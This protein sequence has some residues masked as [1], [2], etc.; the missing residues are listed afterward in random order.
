MT[1]NSALVFIL[2]VAIAQIPFLCDLGN[3]RL[4]GWHTGTWPSDYGLANSATRIAFDFM[5][6]LK[7]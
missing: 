3:S 5:K 7:T 6:T 4:S 1:Q 2:A